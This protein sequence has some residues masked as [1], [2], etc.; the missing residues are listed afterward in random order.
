MVGISV[1]SPARTLLSRDAWSAR[2]SAHTERADHLTAGRRERA[3]RGE[4]HA[5]EDFLDG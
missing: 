3:A 4:S 1:N 2:A 5:I